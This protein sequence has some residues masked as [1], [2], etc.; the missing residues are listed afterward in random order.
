MSANEV[1]VVPSVTTV[2][3]HTL[4]G[5]AAGINCTLPKK[6]A[7]VDIVTLQAETSRAG[8]AGKCSDRVHK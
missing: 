2:G 7:V 4:F 1:L 5:G 6:T 3:L 8:S